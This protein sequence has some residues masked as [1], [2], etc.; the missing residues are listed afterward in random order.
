MTPSVGLEILFS[1]CE[2]ASNGNK[3]MKPV[4][5]V[6]FIMVGAILILTIFR[7]VRC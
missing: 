1:L 7:L 2:K 4:S 5:N 3:A 6:F